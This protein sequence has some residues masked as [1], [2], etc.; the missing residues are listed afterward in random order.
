MSDRFELR[1]E[2]GS[3]SLA[4][5]FHA[6]DSSTMSIFRIALA[7]V[8]IPETREETVTVAQ[9]A[10]TQA[11]AEGAKI[12]CFPEC[13]VPGYRGLGRVVPPPDA[14]FLERAWATIAAAAAKANVAVVL[15]TER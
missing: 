12:I 6:V 10:I 8:R 3:L 2:V 11:S 14:S 1:N 9:D 5:V 7:N 4:S 15:G 13:F